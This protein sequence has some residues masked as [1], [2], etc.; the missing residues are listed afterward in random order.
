LYEKG[1]FDFN[2][3][4]K[5][6]ETCNPQPRPSRNYAMP[7]NNMLK[8]METFLTLSRLFR[9]HPLCGSFDPLSNLVP[10]PGMFY[11]K[12]RKF[13]KDQVHPHRGFHNTLFSYGELKYTLGN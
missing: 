6:C 13:R 9:D 4:T 7:Q 12:N 1:I 11:L 2:L 8:G 10:C 3:D 5:C